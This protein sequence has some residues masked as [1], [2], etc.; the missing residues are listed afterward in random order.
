MTVWIYFLN[1]WHFQLHTIYLAIAVG[2][3][4]FRQIDSKGFPYYGYVY[5]SN[6]EK[7]NPEL[8]TEGAK[9]CICETCFQFAPSEGDLKASFTATDSLFTLDSALRSGVHSCVQWMGWEVAWYIFVKEEYFCNL[10]YVAN[11][12][13]S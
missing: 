4:P 1:I 10:N 3:R 11:I 8:L 9:N 5:I 6:E 13:K 2:N 12:A 7:I